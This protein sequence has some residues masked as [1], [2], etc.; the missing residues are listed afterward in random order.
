MFIIYLPL[1]S[2]KSA[3]HKAACRKSDCILSLANGRLIGGRYLLSV[4]SMSNRFNDA[5]RTQI[6][7]NCWTFGNEAAT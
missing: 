5:M 2:E 6:A 3:Q 7:S 4:S 1:T